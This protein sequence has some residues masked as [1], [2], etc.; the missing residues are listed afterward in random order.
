MVAQFLEVSCG[1]TVPGGVM[2]CSISAP[3]ACAVVLVNCLV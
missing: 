3:A 1:C 2:F